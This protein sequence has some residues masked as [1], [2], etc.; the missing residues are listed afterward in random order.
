M[1]FIKNG[2]SFL[3]VTKNYKVP[4]TLQPDGT[5]GVTGRKGSI[6]F[7][8]VKKSD[9]IIMRGQEYKRLT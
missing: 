1:E 4:I 3:L 5:L 7:S 9:T 8:H 6:V 2:K